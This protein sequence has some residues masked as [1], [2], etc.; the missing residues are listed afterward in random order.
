[1][2]DKE[3]I[4]VVAPRAGPFGGCRRTI[5][6]VL[7]L[8]LMFFFALFLVRFGIL[9]FI[10]NPNKPP[11][12]TMT[13]VLERIRLVS[14]LTTVR[15][16]YSSII[17]TERDLPPLLAGLYRDQLVLVAVGNITA[18]IDVSKLSDDDVVVTNEQIS[19]TL[20]PPEL[21]DCFLNES[22]SYVA[23]RETGLFA[24]PAPDFDVQA[25]RFAVRYFRNQS[26]EQGILDDAQAQAITVME[27]L[28]GAFYPDEA[29]VVTVKPHTD[30]VQMTET[31]Q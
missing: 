11:T 15:Y 28:L 19:I 23:S 26:L 9:D 12:I 3:K 2:A 24:A 13:T 7:L 14:E 25:R 21:F 30:A 4:V 10:I 29:I 16:T 17:T 27:G 1:M 8:V 6:S 5:I 20:P 31:C 22:E 18:G